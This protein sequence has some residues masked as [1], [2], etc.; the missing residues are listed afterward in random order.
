M[1]QIICDEETHALAKRLAKLTGKP[2]TETVRHA[3]RARLDQVEKSLGMSW[4]VDEL[5]RI[6]LACAKLPRRD[7]RSADEIIGYDNWGVV[8]L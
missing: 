4:R 2:L 1:A 6:A 8:G 7:Q 3:L 5:D